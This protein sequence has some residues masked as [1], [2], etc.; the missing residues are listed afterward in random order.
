MTVAPAVLGGFVLL[1]F[2]LV[3][4]AYLTWLERKFASRIQARIGPHRV[5]LAGTMQPWADAL[6]LITKEDTTPAGAEP[7]AYNLAPV[8]VVV[9]ALLVYAVLPFSE[10]IQLA[11][12][13]LGLLFFLAVAG[14]IVFGV[15]AAGWA[16]NNKYAML[17][18]MRAAAQMIAYEVPLALAALVPVLLA[19]TLSLRGVV[20]AQAGGAWFVV[21][22]FGLVAFLLFTLASLAESNRSP[23]DVPEAE[24]ELVSGANVEYSGM[25]FSF[26][27]LGE[28]AH[29]WA[30]SALTAV[31][32]LGG[33]HGPLLPGWLWLL[34][35]AYGVF[36]LVMW[37]RWSLLRVRVDQL[38][39]LNWK[40]LVPVA[41]ANVFGAALWAVLVG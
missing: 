30:S 24:S 32:F 13:D 5:G 28:Y 38:M 3:T 1:N 27:Y 26:F 35:K 33:W 17:A 12:L 11:D 41:L 2:V 10:R 9:P 6:K 15:M 22:P 19:G 37:I 39:D 36:V 16:S 31:L 34:L 20:D 25:K 4:A 14:L 40:L 23:F 7:I 18:A 8:L 21:N 29:L